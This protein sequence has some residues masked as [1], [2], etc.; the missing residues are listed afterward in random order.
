MRAAFA[1]RAALAACAVLAVGCSSTTAVDLTLTLA[2]DVAAHTGELSTLALHVDGDAAPFDRTLPIAGKF[3]GGHETLQYLPHATS[4]TLT[5][6]VTLADAAAHPLGMGTAT[7]AL[8][9]HH[10]VPLALTIGAGATDGDGGSDDLA[11]GGDDLATTAPDMTMPCAAIQVSTLAGTGAAGYVDGAP[12]VA[13][14]S[15]ASGITSDSSGTLYVAEATHLRKV[16]ATGTV[17]TLASGFLQ[18]LRVA[19]DALGTCYV[20]DSANDEVFA[21]SSGGTKSAGFLSGGLINVALSPTVNGPVY[22]WDTQDAQ[23]R[24]H[25]STQNMTTTSTFSGSASGFMDGAAAAAKYAN[26]PDMIFDSASILWAADAGNFRIRK[27]LGDGSVTTFAGSSTQGHVDGVGAAAQF[28]SLAGITVDNAAHR[29]FVTDGFTVRMIT[30]SGAVSTI[31]GSTSGLVDGNGCVAKLGA[32]KGL[33]YF[34]GA[35]FVVDVERI[36]KIVLP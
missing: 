31:V 33:T 25:D 22:F 29:L 35:L 24:V 28:D 10:S 32:P 7:V 2:G 19:C 16:S 27:I 14:F 13:Q 34:A 3:G 6:T 9:A 30:Q 18:G 1:A 4:G 17:S 20:A 8:S 5:F 11:T 36:R 23:V 15:M 21:V 26:V 12:N